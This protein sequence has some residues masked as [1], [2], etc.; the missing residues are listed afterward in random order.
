MNV[1]TRTK[2]PDDILPYDIDLDRWLDREDRVSSASVLVEDGSVIATE[3]VPSSRVVKIW[4]AGGEAGETNTIRITV[5]TL[6]G[7]T[8]EFCL[9]LR[10]SRC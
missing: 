5:H 1:G 10:I 6:A 8:K 3:V 2:G 9:H 7:L 4:L